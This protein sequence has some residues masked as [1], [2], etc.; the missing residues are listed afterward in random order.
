MP[1]MTESSK[2]MSLKAFF[3][4]LEG[5]L[6]TLSADD[7]RSVLRNMAKSVPPDGR[8]AFLAQLQ[9]G[10]KPEQAIAEALGQDDQLERPAQDSA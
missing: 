6:D 9:P 5:R 4:A 8:H 7:L 3:E 1:P 2:R 10:G